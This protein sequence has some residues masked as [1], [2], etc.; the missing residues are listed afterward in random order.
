MP[1]E[2]NLSPKYE[3]N[4]WP[5]ISRPDIKPP[6]G[7]SL[8]LVTAVNRVHNHNLSPDG[9]HIAFIW[10]REEL[11]DV[12]IMPA[13]GGWPRRITADRPAFQYWWEEIPAWSP[14]S[15]WLAFTVGDDVY[16]ASVNEGSPRKISG[17]TDNAFSPVWM[18][19]S[20][21]IIIAI[22]RNEETHLL[23]TDRY[24]SWPSLIS[25][26]LGE[27][28]DPQPSPDGKHIIFLHH[29]MEDLN[30]QE[31]ILVEIGKPEL[32]TLVSYEHILC[33]QPRW[34]PDGKTI[35]YLCQKSGWWEV[36][37]LNP[38]E[39]KPIQLT[40]CAHDLADIEWSP[41]GKWLAATINRNGS[42]D[43]CLVNAKNGKL[44][45]LRTSQGVFMRPD[46]SPDSTFLTVE[47]SNPRLP[48]D[49]YRI[50]VNTEAPERVPDEEIIQL[51]F[52]NLPTMA[53]L[54]MVMPQQVSYRSFGGVEIPATLYKPLKPN[55]AAIVY[56]H[57]GPREQF[58][59]DWDPFIQ[60]LVAKGY[61]F[62]AIN[63]RG[64]TGY[65]YEYA[66][67]NDNDWGG[68]DA[69]DCLYA[70]RYL[71]GLDWIDAG[72]LAIMGA[73]YGGYMVA[74][75]L[76]RDPDYLFS[77]GISL[78]GDA[79]PI[80]SWALT[81]RNTRLYTEMQI[82]TPANNWSVY[83]DS[84]TIANVQNIRK[85]VLI[86]HG[87]EDD[88]VHPLSSEQWVEALRNANKTFEYKLYAGESHG[89]LKRVNILDAYARMERFLDWYLMPEV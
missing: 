49:L 34:S 51:T 1:E 25:R 40:H 45:D 87:L 65:G 74:C 41:D 64:S 62:L 4:G 70:A 88:V 5:A 26:T 44:V 84:S 55:R 8:P 42:L 60:Y 53:S 82:G 76:S 38:E 72:R 85:P 11:S 22:E 28:S 77:C 52:S 24:G 23:L 83:Y 10:D 61:T 19:D 35:A 21:G 20:T 31:I 37:L 54:Q 15:Q 13:S 75:A 32:H 68:G 57:G 46:W 50:P 78:Y 81:E 43:L 6:E 14:D 12:Y 67:L 9:R 86:L 18:P 58:Q 89:F 56:P 79:D 29:P 48:P 36:W 66:H 80:N 71:S 17:F 69:Q 27:D 30:R 3:R 2:I 39:I 7:W 33:A 47:Y 73:S 63:Y 59:M 16:V